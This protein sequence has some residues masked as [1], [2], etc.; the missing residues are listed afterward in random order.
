M[1]Q[2]ELNAEGIL[3]C[4]L[5][6]DEIDRLRSIKHDFSSN[7]RWGNV[8]DEALRVLLADV[9]DLI[10]G[11]P[12][13]LVKESPLDSLFPH[14]REFLEDETKT[15]LRKT[16]VNLLL[17]KKLLGAVKTK[18]TQHIMDILILDEDEENELLGV[19]EDE[20]GNRRVNSSDSETEIIA[21]INAEGSQC[22]HIDP[23]RRLMRA[24][25]ITQLEDE[26][27]TYCKECRK[28][29]KAVPMGKAFRGR[30]KKPTVC[31]HPDVEWVKGKEG[32][33]AKCADRYELECGYTIED[34]KKLK[35][36][37]WQAVGL[38]EFGDDPDSDEV[39]IL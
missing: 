34:P 4:S 16:Y 25:G 27:Q 18:V 15:Q 6:M 13:T 2:D 12:G 30:K 26:L 28:V 5:T 33:I 9:E 19:R 11:S 8:A 20:M 35:K 24:D 1:S 3:N 17:V 39:I 32:E 23:I 38:E 36:Y 10:H 7:I 31:D 21:R 22:L 14:E 37:K 29:I